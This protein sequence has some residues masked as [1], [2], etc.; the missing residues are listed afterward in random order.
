MTFVEIFLEFENKL[1]CE[2][3]PVGFRFCSIL[4]CALCLFPNFCSHL[5]STLLLPFILVPC[6]VLSLR[7]TFSF[8][9]RSLAH[10]NERAPRWD[11]ASHERLNSASRNFVPR[12]SQFSCLNVWP[13]FSIESNF[14][15]VF[16][17]VVHVLNFRSFL[18]Y[19]LSLEQYFVVKVRILIFS[20][21]RNYCAL[22]IFVFLYVSRF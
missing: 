3:D 20:Q 21:F 22:L 14:D 13:P 11:K 8:F 15:A 10:Q 19:S 12:D 18:I 2:T 17:F 5:I 9:D 16:S 1:G 4:F 6:L 7:S